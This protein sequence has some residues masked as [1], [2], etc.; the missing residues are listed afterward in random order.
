MLFGLRVM[1]PG[2]TVFGFQPS[3]GG[4]YLLSSNNKTG[5]RTGVGSGSWRSIIS[6]LSKSKALQPYAEFTFLA[7]VTG[8][9]IVGVWSG[10]A[11]PTSVESGYG[12]GAAGNS[13]GY[14][15]D[16]TLYYTDAPLDS[17]SS[18]A[19]NDVIGVGIQNDGSGTIRFWKNGVLA[20]S[21][22]VNVAAIA[23]SASSPVFVGISGTSTGVPGGSYTMN[24]GDQPFFNLPAGYTPWE[25]A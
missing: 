9:N 18:Y 3:P 14:H 11:T 21:P 8:N 19:V 1:G 24:L 4:S 12:G 13:T 5:T 23:G 15:Q 2:R 10:A 6:A 7:N 16:G 22:A 20:G 17:Y 25:Q